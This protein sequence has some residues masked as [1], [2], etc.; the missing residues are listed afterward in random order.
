MAEVKSVTVDRVTYNVAQASAEK[1]KSLLQLVGA[2]ITH[3]KATSRT[4][5]I[6]EGFLVGVLMRLKEET[7][8][9]VASIVLVQTAKHGGD[10]IVD[11]MDF[12]GCILS[13]YKL[14]AAAI[15]VNLQDFF[16]YLDSPDDE[17]NLKAADQKT[18]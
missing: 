16:T 12:Q 3:N 9:E 14:V 17:S 18:Q 8:D 4:V 10:R 15:K 13:Y 2:I 1:Q 7:F 11:I 6:D 5:E